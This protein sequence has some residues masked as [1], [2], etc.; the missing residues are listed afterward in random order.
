MSSFYDP[1]YFNTTPWDPRFD[2]LSNKLRGLSNTGEYRSVPNPIGRLKQIWDRDQ[3]NPVASVITPVDFLRIYLAMYAEV[4]ITP[5]TTRLCFSCISEATPRIMDMK[6]DTLIARDPSLLTT[7]Q[8]ILDESQQVKQ[9]SVEPSKPKEVEVV[10]EDT[11]DVD[12]LFSYLVK[13]SH[14]SIEYMMGDIYDKEDNHYKA[15]NARIGEL[16]TIIKAVP[17]EWEIH[18]P[19]D[20]I[21]VVSIACRLLKRKYV[22]SECNGVGNEAVKVGIITH[23]WDFDTHL[24]KYPTAFYIF[25]HLGRFVD[26]T[27]MSSVRCIIYDQ[28]KL[29][30]PGFR[31]LHYSGVLSTNCIEIKSG[32]FIVHYTRYPD[33]TRMNIKLNT[34]EETIKHELEVQ[35]VYDP[36]STVMAVEDKTR[37]VSGHE[38]VMSER[39][40]ASKLTSKTGSTV[41]QEG[42]TTYIAGETTRVY[43]PDKMVTVNTERDVTTLDS[44]YD[45]QGLILSKVIVPFHP[46]RLRYAYSNR[47]IVPVIVLGFQEVYV[48][49]DQEDS[50][51]VFDVT[52]FARD[53]TY[54]LETDEYVDTLAAALQHQYAAYLRQSYK[55]RIK[56]KV[57]DKSRNVKGH[58]G[59]RGGKALKRKQKKKT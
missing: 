44:T 42:Y 37:V 29:T 25:S 33:I 40:V 9:S 53:G 7:A 4:V 8:T 54:A 17:P 47:A 14:G 32:P 20:G 6:F 15:Y 50:T 31:H 10:S 2:S 46:G 56:P 38:Y 39:R 16:I 28:M 43:L 48:N 24:S 36:S 13:L 55:V 23:S 45:L 5:G 35:G 26:Y 22:S 58:T 3:C 34:R 41:T 21:G 18:A 52:L 30:L 1:N 19:G 12:S 11:A 59:K 49:V 57:P 27:K 51:I